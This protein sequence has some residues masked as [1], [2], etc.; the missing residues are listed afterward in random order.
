[1][2]KLRLSCRKKEKFE[3]LKGLEVSKLTYRLEISLF[4]RAN[5]NQL[6][7]AKKNNEPN[8]KLTEIV[9]CE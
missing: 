5:E 6:V 2:R 1:M 8:Q 7:I 3:T 9:V 4:Q